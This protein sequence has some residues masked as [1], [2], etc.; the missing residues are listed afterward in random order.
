MGMGDEGESVKEM[1]LMLFLNVMASRS[2]A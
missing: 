2:S 1:M